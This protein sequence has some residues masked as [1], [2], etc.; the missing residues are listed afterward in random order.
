MLRSPRFSG[1]KE[2]GKG[3]DSSSE[4]SSD[5]D[6]E[7]KDEEDDVVNYNS[8]LR[9][10]QRLMIEPTDVDSQFAREAANLMNAPRSAKSEH[11][12][13]FTHAAQEEEE[14][15]QFVEKKLEKYSKQAE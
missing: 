5:S 6:E 12:F 7:G 2:E 14:D 11:F 1:P 4:G 3:S 10:D 13:D 9:T 8:A 15:W